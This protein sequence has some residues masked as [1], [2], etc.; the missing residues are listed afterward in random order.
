MSPFGSNDQA[1][2]FS[3]KTSQEIDEQVSKF[4][5]DNHKLATNILNENRDALDR[6]AE[7][8]I[9]WETLDFEQV[10]K[11]VKGEDIGIPLVEEEPVVSKDRAVADGADNTETLSNDKSKESDKSKMMIQLL[12]S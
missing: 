4:L 6:L 3:D 8:L 9:L 5:I 7:G 1:L 12:P 2:D 10:D 11:L